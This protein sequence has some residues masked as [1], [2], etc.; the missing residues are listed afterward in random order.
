MEEKKICLSAEDLINKIIELMQDEE[1][2]IAGYQYVIDTITC[3]KII[4]KLEEIRD[5]EKE[6][7]SELRDIL[8]NITSL[9]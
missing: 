3:K 1:E 9:D 2:A 4:K 6:P 7:L 8:L 5:D